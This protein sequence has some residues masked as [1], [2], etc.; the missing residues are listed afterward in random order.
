FPAWMLQLL[1]KARDRIIHLLVTLW[2]R[3]F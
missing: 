2:D 1:R 3:L